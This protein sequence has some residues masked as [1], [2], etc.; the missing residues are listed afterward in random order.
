MAEFVGGLGRMAM[1]AFALCTFEP[2]TVAHAQNKGVDMDLLRRAGDI[3]WQAQ[4]CGADEAQLRPYFARTIQL[5]SASPKT[6]SANKT[7]DVWTEYQ[8]H[9]MCR[10]NQDC[11]GP[12]LAPEACATFLPRFKSMRINQANWRIDEG[13][14]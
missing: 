2:W 5:I 13:L 10:N 12:K 1:A 8:V 7:M 3:F 9:V 6:T 11:A 14:H 4:R